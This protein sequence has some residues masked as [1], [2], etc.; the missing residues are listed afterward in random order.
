MINT[1]SVFPFR[2]NTLHRLIF[3][4]FFVSFVCFIMERDI[5]VFWRYWTTLYDEVFTSW[6]LVTRQINW[7][8]GKWG[9]KKS[10]CAYFDAKFVR[11]KNIF[12]RVSMSS[13]STTVAQTMSESPENE[14]IY[15]ISIFADDFL[16]DN[17]SDVNNNTYRISNTYSKMTNSVFSEQND[18]ISLFSC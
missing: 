2:R 4:T 17:L 9:Y 14:Q 12:T 16:D 1:F 5:V 15:V 8:R 7:R 3:Q 6:S 13:A 11:M 18:F 10:R